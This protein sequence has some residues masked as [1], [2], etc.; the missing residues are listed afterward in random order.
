MAAEGSALSDACLICDRG[1]L[2]VGPLPVLAGT[3]GGLGP[4]MSRELPFLPML[5][6]FTLPNLPEFLPS[7]GSCTRHDVKRHGI[8]KKRL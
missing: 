6:P 1:D 3:A 5:D 2:V 7:L 8:P 4:A